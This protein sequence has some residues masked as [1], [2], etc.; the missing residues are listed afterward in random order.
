[1]FA[2]FTEE[3]CTGTGDVIT[4]TGATDGMLPFS[5]SY[6]DGDEV[7]YTI[8]DGSTKISGL[9]VYSGGTITRKDL[10]NYNGTSVDASPDSNITLSSN[11]KTIRVAADVTTLFSG[12]FHAVTEF[13]VPDNITKHDQTKDINIGSNMDLYPAL[14]LRPVVVNGFYTVVTT[15][16]SDTINFRRSIYESKDG[17]PYRKLADS[18]DIS[19]VIS[20][21]GT[22]VSS[23]SSPLILHPGLYFFGCTG[24]NGGQV[25]SCNALDVSLSIGRVF[26]VGSGGGRGD[27]FR[28]GGVSG[29]HPSEITGEPGRNN[30]PLGPLGFV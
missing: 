2:N 21:T 7:A 23:L 25:R 8:E 13:R 16:S 29:V 22:K 19:S 27:I 10:W 6:Q 26:N 30:N 18:G 17:F 14:F 15:A 24:T 5:A 4:L 1:M 28:V 11:T 20:T 3:T 12:G 9:G